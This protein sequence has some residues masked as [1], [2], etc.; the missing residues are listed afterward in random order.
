MWE[1]FSDIQS[2]KL[3]PDWSCE[4]KAETEHLTITLLGGE[5]PEAKS[6]SLYI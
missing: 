2:Q 4:L 1:C 5:R 3:G 6:G